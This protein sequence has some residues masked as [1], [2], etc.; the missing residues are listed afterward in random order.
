MMAV[1]AYKGF[2]FTWS[3]ADLVSRV[4][5]A[6]ADELAKESFTAGGFVLKSKIHEEGEWSI[7]ANDRTLHVKIPLDFT[8]SKPEGLFSVEGEGGIT[9]HLTCEFLPASEGKLSVDVN[10]LAHDWH[11]PPVVNMGSIDF[12]IEFLSD[13]VVCR[14]R[15]KHLENWVQTINEKWNIADILSSFVRQHARNI[16]IATKPEWYFNF[17]I[18]NWVLVGFQ[19][20][21][22]ELKM[23]LYLQFDA[24]LSD[25]ATPFLPQPMQSVH[26]PVADL[27][28][29]GSYNIDINCSFEGLERILT[30]YLNHNEIGG[31]TFDVEKII[32]R[33]T[34]FFEIKVILRAPVQGTV[35]LSAEPHFDVRN[36]ILDFTN[37]KVD[38]TASQFFYQLTSPLIEKIIRNRIEEIVPIKLNPLLETA[39]TL[40]T[41]SL[42]QKDI[43][44]KTKDLRVTT[45][46][47]ETNKC[48][49]TASLEEFSCSDL[50]ADWSVFSR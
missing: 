35:T 4:K 26:I 19:D 44:L 39:V 43:V 14:I 34:S 40:G 47:F 8:F 10:L 37:I 20:N 29:Q 31:K 50:Q 1:Q 22:L 2:G 49:V 48:K 33:N 25:K 32:I 23:I 3:K 13:V 7:Q 41:D 15:D 11:R 21:G 6:L 30:H 9:L 24:V 42:L 5:N 17:D 28:T 27:M 18:F 46:A 36:Q 12:P 38:I 45:V 16:V